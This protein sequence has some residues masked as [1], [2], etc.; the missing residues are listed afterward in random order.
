MSNRKCDYPGCNQP[1]TITCGTIGCNHNVCDIHGNGGIETD[2]D[3]VV[4]ICWGCDGK[5]WGDTF[6]PPLK[7]NPLE[8]PSIGRTSASQINWNGEK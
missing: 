7:D 5:G 3:H 8:L 1:A 4:E 2:S 6:P